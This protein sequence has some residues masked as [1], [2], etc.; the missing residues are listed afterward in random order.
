M[1]IDFSSLK[2]NSSSIIPSVKVASSESVSHET[3][4]KDGDSVEISDEAL[5]KKRNENIHVDL[6]SDLA[7]K[8][9]KKGAS[10]GG[11]ASSLV[12]AHIE[13]LKKQ[14]E[15]VKQQIKR[16][17]GNKSEAAKKMIEALRGQL[18][19]LNAALM[20]AME[21]KLEAAAGGAK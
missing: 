15:M 17:E 14:I 5:E 18:M 20:E 9:S 7:A 11:G 19:Q 16:L 2:F 10:G 6:K 3:A 12:D 4:L 8:D 21:S 1:S 13:K